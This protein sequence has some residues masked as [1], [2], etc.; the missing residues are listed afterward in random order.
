MIIQ[1]HACVQPVLILSSLF[2][3]PLSS[4]YAIYDTNTPTQGFISNIMCLWHMHFD[5]KE[6]SSLSLYY[7]EMNAINIRYIT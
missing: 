5:S 3:S 7:N 2:F 1:V 4:N 6:T